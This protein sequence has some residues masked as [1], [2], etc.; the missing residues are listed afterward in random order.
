MLTWPQELPE[1]VYKSRMAAVEYRV[2]VNCRKITDLAKRCL[3]R[4]FRGYQTSYLAGQH[5]KNG[6]YME[7]SEVWGAD[8]SSQRAKR[9]QNRGDERAMIEAADRNSLTILTKFNPSFD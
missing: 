9:S 5:P 8:R 7:R 4:G 2:L 1:Y 6:V 3:V